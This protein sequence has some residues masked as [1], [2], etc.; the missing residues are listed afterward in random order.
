MKFFTFAAAGL[1]LAIAA[2]PVAAQNVEKVGTP[3]G[4]ILTAAKVKAGATT[5]YLSGNLASPIDPARP[6]EFGD[7]KTQTISTLKKI[8]AL[9]EAQGMTM[10]DIIRMDAFLT[11]APGM[12]GKMDFNGFNAGFAEF[13]GNAETPPPPPAPPCRSPPWPA[14]ISWWN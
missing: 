6:T 4:R 13:F 2:A 7:T 3:G 12:D 1:A 10:K 5:V 14:R 8:K 11:A 9:L